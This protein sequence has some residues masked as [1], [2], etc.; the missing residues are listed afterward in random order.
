MQRCRPERMNV[1]RIFARGL[2]L[3][4]GLFWVIAGAAAEYGF[5]GGQALGA[6]K[7]AAIPFGFAALVLAVGWYREYWAAGLLFSASAVVV[8]WGVIAV[9]EPFVWLIMGVTLFGPMLLAGVLFALAARMQGICVL[10]GVLTPHGQVEGAR[11]ADA[12]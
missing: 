4:G 2:V 10:E 5:R 6:A 7:Y 9:W 11:S 1:E 12:A 3:A 8:A